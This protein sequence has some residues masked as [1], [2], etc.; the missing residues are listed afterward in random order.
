M[1]ILNSA[2]LAGRSDDDFDHIQELEKKP[3]SDRT[4]WERIELLTF[5]AIKKL[6]FVGI[7]LSASV[8]Y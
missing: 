4:L 6:G 2:A 8:I 3:K 1:I 5:Y 7:L